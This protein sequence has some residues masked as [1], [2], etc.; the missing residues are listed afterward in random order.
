MSHKYH[1]SRASGNKKTGAIPVTTTS[2]ESCPPTCSFK[3]NG[4]YA[5]AG[6]LLWHWRKVNDTGFDLDTLCAHIKTLPLGQL[7]RHNQA[8][9]L[10]GQDGTIDSKA[11]AKLVKANKK[12][13]G[14]TY[15]HYLP[16]EANVETVRS[17]NQNGFTINWSAETLAQADEFVALRAGPVAVVLPK[18]QM[19]NLKT[20]EGRSVTICPAYLHNI[21]CANCGTCQHSERKAIVGFPAHGTSY[22][23]VQKVFFMEK[24]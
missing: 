9:D 4:C 3:G 13:K 14:F 10:P 15:T 22:K 2:A 18:D 23:R 16:S 1:F 6:P 7:W 24:A 20:P 17:A 12:R 11:L 21:D 5:E 8:G 19:T